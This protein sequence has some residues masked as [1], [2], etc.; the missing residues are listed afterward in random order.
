MMFKNSLAYPIFKIIAE[1]VF[2][3][4]SSCS[5]M[6][7]FLVVK[8]S[9]RWEFFNGTN[10]YNISPVPFTY[11]IINKINLFYKLKFT[12]LEFIWIEQN[13][14]R[15]VSMYH[16]IVI[17]CFVL[18]VNVV[19]VHGMHKQMFCYVSYLFRIYHCL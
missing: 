6:I 13:N 15:Y 1:Y 11:F 14:V 10:Q 5:D 16:V 2:R 9:Y 8:F 3:T 4:L 7:Y 17:L 12:Y 19:F 18:T